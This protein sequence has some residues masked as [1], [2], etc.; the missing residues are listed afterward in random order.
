VKINEVIVE[1]RLDELPAS[2]AASP[3]IAGIK[4]AMQGFQGGQGFLNKLQSAAA[5]YQAGATGAEGVK[6]QKQISDLK[7]RDWNKAI[8]QNPNILKAADGGAQALR[9]FIANNETAQR[10]QYNP[11][12]PTDMSQA[13][14]KDYIFQTT[15]EL[16]SMKTLGHTGQAGGAPMT[17][18]GAKPQVHKDVKITNQNPLVLRYKTTDF[19]RNDQGEW[20][21]VT[22]PKNVLSQGWQAF[23]DGQEN[24]LVPASPTAAAPAAAPAAVTP[25]PKN[26]GAKQAAITPTLK[27]P[28]ATP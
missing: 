13:G 11:P 15:G 23:L 16:E 17:S 5:G 9:D 27:T 10:L 20:A 2:L 26:Y 1:Q 14:V 28:A 4:G 3:T 24:L 8:G 19:I 21:P 6:L 25:T 18:P 7:L 12:M 22:S